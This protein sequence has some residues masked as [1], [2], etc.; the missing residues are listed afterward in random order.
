MSTRALPGI[1]SLQAWFAEV[2]RDAASVRALRF[3]VG[4]TIAIALAYGVDWPLAFLF[5]VLS[6]VILALPLPM[7]TLAAGLRNMLQSLLAFG[8]GL[9]SAVWAIAA[10][11]GLAL[12]FEVA[13]ATLTV[14]RLLGAAYL[15]WLAFTV[16]RHA[17][18]PMPQ[19][20]LSRRPAGLSSSVRLGLV[21]QIANPKPA[22]FFGAIFVGLVPPGS[23]PAWYAAL[24][25][26]IFLNETL[27]Y[28]FVGGVFSGARA[29]D[30]YARLKLWIDRVFAGGSLRGPAGRLVFR[31]VT[32]FYARGHH[33]L[34]ARFG[35]TR[36]VA[37]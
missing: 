9:G 25:F 19:P 3:A 11:S 12:V 30:T 2:A 24:I 31:D 7:P 35:Q 18:E 37:G 20:S 26:M 4:V 16:W 17:S 28:V 14:L 1:K 22:I 13:P 15:C 21:T 32:R 36:N 6:A 23:H 5:P 34:D 8:I 29:R 33:F 27:W 10:L